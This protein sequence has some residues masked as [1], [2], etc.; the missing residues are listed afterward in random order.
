MADLSGTEQDYVHAR[1]RSGRAD[2]EWRTLL[3]EI[4]SEGRSGKM[5]GRF[6]HL[7]LGAQPL[8]LV[9]LFLLF[10]SCLNVPANSQGLLG[11]FRLSRLVRTAIGKLG[12]ARN[13]GVH[14]TIPQCLHRILRHMTTS[15]CTSQ[16]C[17]IWHQWAS[18]LTVL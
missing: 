8:P 2:E 14:I 9:I 11:L 4:S 17:D 7:N 12:G 18:V 6:R 15:A 1:L 10:T 3:E 5:E 16:W 13:T